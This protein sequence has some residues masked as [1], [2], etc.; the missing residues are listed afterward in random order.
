MKNYRKFVA[1]LVLALVLSV[2]AFAGEI[3]TD[4]TS[5][6]PAPIAASGEIHTGKDS[7]TPKADITT[8]LALE[9]LQSLLSLL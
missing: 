8:G 6:P 7:S 1:A 4:V 3:H 5:S 9:L 2:P